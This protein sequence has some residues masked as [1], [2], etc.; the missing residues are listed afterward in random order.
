MKSNLELALYEAYLSLFKDFY[1]CIKSMHTQLNKKNSD[2]NKNLIELCLP[3]YRKIAKKIIEETNA[4][5]NTT[6]IYNSV[7]FTDTMKS[8][9]NYIVNIEQTIKKCLK[10]DSNETEFYILLFIIL[11]IKYMII[12]ETSAVF[13]NKLK[14]YSQTDD[15]D[16]LNKKILKNDYG[17][18]IEDSYKYDMNEIINEIKNGEVST[19]FNEI[20]LFKY[21]KLEYYNSNNITI[22]V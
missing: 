16:E 8:I 20:I 11:E 13:T 15:D 18:E 14:S 17:I 12:H 19:E 3:K 5:I 2:F 6:I 7:F 21:I 10:K 9:R 4:D 1:D 22:Y